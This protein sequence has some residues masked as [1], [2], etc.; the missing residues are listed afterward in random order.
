MTSQR[1]LERSI[2]EWMADEAA[3]HGDLDV[4]D[5]ML[6]TTSRTRPA[7]R[8]YA[9]LKE[10]PMHAQTRVAVGSP[11]RRLAL[12]AAL[13]G[14]LVIGAVAAGSVL[15]R[16]SPVALD[17][18][19]GF[20]GDA[21]RSG[22][23]TH[24]PVGN[25]TLTWRFDAGA[26]VN[27]AIAIRGDLV[28]APDDDG[29]LHALA[30]D[31]GL[32][33]WSFQVDTAPAEGPLAI[34]DQ[35][36]VRDGAGTIYALD[37]QGTLQWRS[38][39]PIRGLSDLTMG[40][41]LLYAGSLDGEVAAIDAASG[42]ERWRTP[43]GRSSVHAPAYADG[44]VIALTD[45]GALVS[46]EASAGEVTWTT[47]VGSGTG[48]PVVAAGIVYVGSDEDAR[49]TLR[50]YDLQTGLEVV[51]VDDRVTSPSVADAIGYSGGGTGEVVALDLK[52]GEVRWRTAFEGTTRAPALAGDVVYVAADG[53]RRVVALA[54][55][56]G[57]ELWRFDLD[58]SAHC[59]IAV[60]QGQVFIG[61]EAGSVYAIGGDGATL[62][63]AARATP[64]VPS[65]APSPLVPSP[66]APELTATVRWSASAPDADFVPWHLARD[67]QGNLWA[68]EGAKDRFAIFSPEGAFL[69]YWGASGT[70]DGEFILTRSNGDTYGAVAFEPDGSFYVL[71]VGNRRV[72]QFDAARTFVRSW[73]GTGTGPGAYTDPVGIVVGPDGRVHV[74][75]GARGMIE[76]YERDGTIV[77]SVPA[78]AGATAKFNAAN[79]LSID[80]DGDFFVILTT[81]VIQLDSEGTSLGSFGAAG[82][83]AGAI[84]D[85][86]MAAG[87]DAA[88]R[89]YVTQGPGRGDQPG[90]L[91]FDPDGTYLGGWGD[92][93]AGDDDVTFPFGMVVDP[94]GDVIVTD[95]GGLP[96]IGF[97]SRLQRY[98]V[99]GLPD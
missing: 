49:V 75:D 30:S 46:I 31:T 79:G 50:G 98:S 67:P 40:G 5:A 19:P 29:R 86:A 4:L 81:H 13:V 3:F 56:T 23:A 27:T 74:L 83:G 84:T 14:L 48:T 36:F 37:L 88:G 68:A 73:G 18:W 33:R 95:A 85:Q 70:G 64:S 9:L 6:A 54:R 24:G 10:S 26:A 32:E 57:H 35:V 53:E 45:D 89:V 71:D 76:T 91:V 90:I 2:A 7:P 94:D 99:S 11:T 60:A 80:A 62:V 69:E 16:P 12:I 65:E 93:G 17:D 66:S 97:K 41:N 39:T 44:H 20:R 63:A 82:S 55:A 87:S 61:T 42:T 25:P 34:G 77:G 52:T 1:T 47:E 8:W 51:E 72:Q 58:G 78:L 22:F 43:I 21:T 28:L 96:D 38:P 92:V 59:C 15:L